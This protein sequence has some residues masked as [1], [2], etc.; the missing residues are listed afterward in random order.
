MAILPIFWR[1]A[2]AV[3][4]AYSTLLAYGGLTEFS[5]TSKGVER[6]L[7]LL[8]HQLSPTSYCYW[9]LSLLHGIIHIIGHSG[10]MEV[11]R[12]GAVRCTSRPDTF[13]DRGMG[14]ESVL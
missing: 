8:Q 9:P 4:G 3:Y 13:G 2:E 14:G 12:H 6:V 5:G 11:Y 7:R 1:Q 10:G